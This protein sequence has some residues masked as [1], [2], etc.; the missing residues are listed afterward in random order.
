MIGLHNICIFFY[1]S[2][3]PIRQDLY[4]ATKDRVKFIRSQKKNP[5]LVYRG[6][7]YN[8]KLTQANG[9]TTWRCSDVSKNK[10]RAVCLTQRSSL[11][12]ARR[13]HSH[14][15]HRERIGVRPLYDVEDD[16]DEY[17]EI[18]TADPLDMNKLNQMMKQDNGLFIE[19]TN[20]LRKS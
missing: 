18:N 2:I 17:V 3:A 16:L 13:Q 1:V 8:K 15:D 6:Y 5:Q 10:C 20:T 19:F 7:I 11:V 12:V 9:H 4:L 14:S